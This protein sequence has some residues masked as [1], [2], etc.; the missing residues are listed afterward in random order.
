MNFRVQR[1]SLCR[2]AP[3]LSAKGSHLLLSLRSDK[4]MGFQGP[5]PLDSPLW[6]LDTVHGLQVKSCHPSGRPGGECGWMAH[7]RFLLLCPLPLITALSAPGYPDTRYNHLCDN[8]GLSCLLTFLHTF[9]PAP[10]LSFFVHPPHSL[11]ATYCATL[12]FTDRVDLSS[13]SVS[14]TAV[15][16]SA[17]SLVCS[18][19]NPFSVI[20]LSFLYTLLFTLRFCFLL[21]P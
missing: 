7:L 17:K 14:M 19:S 21:T 2:V 15:L 20:V 4:K 18:F 5:C 1:W 11:W 8:T 16:S 6:A 9:L 12:S 13:A 3:R 10:A